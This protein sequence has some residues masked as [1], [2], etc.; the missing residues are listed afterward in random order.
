MRRRVCYSIGRIDRR[1]P[2]E[3]PEI[4]IRSHHALGAQSGKC[5]RMNGR[6]I[7]VVCS[8]EVLKR[9]WTGWEWQEGEFQVL[10]R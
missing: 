3:T 2:V 10:Y 5:S 9:F 7:A 1:C 8:E 6:V 4:H